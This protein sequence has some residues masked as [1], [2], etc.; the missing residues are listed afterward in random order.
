MVQLVSA[1]QAK[2]LPGRP[3]TD[4]LDAMWLA[5]LTEMGLLRAS[6]VP[7]RPAPDRIFTQRDHPPDVMSF[8]YGFKGAPSARHAYGRNR[9]RELARATGGEQSGRGTGDKRQESPGSRRCGAAAFAA[10]FGRK[11]Y[12]ATSCRARLPRY[13]PQPVPVVTPPMPRHTSRTRPSRSRRARR[14]P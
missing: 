8:L 14:S 12:G 11:P 6:F 4:K 5:R 2:N 13:R 10:P 1:A 9:Q 3:K 7:P